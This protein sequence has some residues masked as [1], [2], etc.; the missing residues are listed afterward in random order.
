[1]ALI[2]LMITC[3]DEAIF[4]TWCEDQLPLYDAVVCLDGSTTE[5]TRQ[6]SQ[7]FSDRLIYLHERDFEI[8]H[9]TDHGL[10]RV[11]HEEIIR[12]FGIGHWIMCCHADEFCY[13]DPRKIAALADAYD[14][15]LVSWY[16]PHFYPHPTELAD[17]SERRSW[18]VPKRHRFYHWGHFATLLPWVEDRLYRGGPDV[19]WD[20]HTHGSVRPHGIIR[21]ASFHPIFRHYKV[22]APDSEWCEIIGGSTYYQDHWRGLEHRTG[23]P[24]R[25]EKF[26]DLFV[27]SVAK[28]TRCDRFDGVFDQPW[29]LGEEFRPDRELQSKIVA[30]S[31]VVVD[32]PKPL[33]GLDNVSLPSSKLASTRLSV[34]IGPENPSFGSW[35]WLGVDLAQELSEDHDTTVFRDDVPD[36]DIIIFFK[37]L[38]EL[39]ALATIRKR[40]RIIYCPVDVYGS[41]AEIDADFNRL[42][43]CDR[44]IVH[45]RRLLPYFQSYAPAVC[46]DHHVKYVIP[47]RDGIVDD[48]PFLWIGEQSNLEPMIEWVRDHKLPGEI[49]VLTNVKGDGCAFNHGTAPIQF[50]TWS[51]EAHLKWLGRCRSAFDIKGKDFRARHKPP[52]KALDFLASGIPFAMN[53]PS[54]SV[55]YLRELGIHVPSPDNLERWLSP[56]YAA[57]CQRFGRVVSDR[58]SLKSLGKAWR[59]ILTEVAA[60]HLV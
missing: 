44:V 49:V 51:P 3:S 4:Q 18:S 57:E 25:V 31:D 39:K 30:A 54:S 16:S 7:R 37:F 9:K 34:G 60:S 11:V 33:G 12:Q 26:E 35:N 28:Y 48:G 36:A 19:H 56:E 29:N 59:S 50:E 17:W 13:H 14:C 53:S 41:S 8:T 2:G 21:E 22:I 27:T 20:D 58:L 42:H 52:A 46:L 45:C 5:Q 10:R 23:V 43:L 32:D 24:F 15:D 55:D 1:M 6:I 38:P 47:T 40:S